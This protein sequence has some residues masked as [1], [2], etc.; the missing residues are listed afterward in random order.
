MTESG[1]KTLLIK[2]MKVCMNGAMIFRHEDRHLHGVPDISCT[3]LGNTT[4]WEVKL[5]PFEHRPQQELRCQQLEQQGNCWYIIFDS[6]SITSHI[7][8]PQFIREWKDHQLHVFDSYHYHAIALHIKG[9]HH[10][11]GRT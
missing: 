3:W 6:G 11:L 2:P 8:E 4:W 9:V 1:L 10:A 5:T 7:I